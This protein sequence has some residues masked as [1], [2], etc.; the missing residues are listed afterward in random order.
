MKLSSRGGDIMS[1][2][3]ILDKEI[4]IN[5]NPEYSPTYIINDLI[6]GTGVDPIDIE[7]TLNDEGHWLW[8]FE[9]LTDDEWLLFKRKLYPNMMALADNKIVTFAKW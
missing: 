5:A 8:N 6:C 3:I 2:T 9:H 1:M 4:I 7:P